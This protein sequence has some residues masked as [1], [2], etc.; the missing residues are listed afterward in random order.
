MTE[1]G[2]RAL[3]QGC[4]RLLAAMWQLFP[5]DLDY[6]AVWPEFLTATAV[7]WPRLSAEVSSADSVEQA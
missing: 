4:L 1:E 7:L 2:E 6:R 5:E 3:R